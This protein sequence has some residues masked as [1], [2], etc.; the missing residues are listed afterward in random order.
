MEQSLAIYLNIGSQINQLIDAGEK[1]TL[2]IT[3]EKLREKS[4]LDY[5]KQTYDSKIDLNIS[6]QT[7][8]NEVEDTFNAYWFGIN[9]RRKF[10]INNNGLCLLIAYCFQ[11]VNESI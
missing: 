5:L 9:E 4:I 7:E 1:I 8:Y 6:T 2:E 10:G 11:K 3:L